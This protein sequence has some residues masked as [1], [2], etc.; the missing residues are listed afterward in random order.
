MQKRAIHLQ[1]S[2]HWKGIYE[3]GRIIPWI[4]QLPYGQGSKRSIP[5]LN[6]ASNQASDEALCVW[7]PTSEHEHCSRAHTTYGSLSP[8][9]FSLPH[10]WVGPI[11]TNNSLNNPPLGSTFSRTVWVP[12]GVSWVPCG[13]D[14]GWP[15]NRR[16]NSVETANPSEI[17]EIP[18]EREDM[19]AVY[20]QFS[21]SRAV[22]QI[23]E[24]DFEVLLA[25]FIQYRERH[26]AM[27]RSKRSG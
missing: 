7:P 5:F 11:R 15:W 13:L 27:I 6:P 12:S 1:N 22:R 4:A 18:G 19:S 9:V 26:K 21:Q 25:V 10:W 2:I 14:W 3:A 23:D 24:R 17:V 8:S 16:A 20:A